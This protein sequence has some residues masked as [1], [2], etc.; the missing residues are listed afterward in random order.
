MFI[1]F[2]IQ[3]DDRQN[4]DTK[5]TIKRE[6]RTMNSSLV[7]SVATPMEGRRG[8]RSTLYAIGDNLYFNGVVR[9]AIQ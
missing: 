2:S 3:G 4:V 6:M 1:Y 5:G 9:W 8:K 7:G